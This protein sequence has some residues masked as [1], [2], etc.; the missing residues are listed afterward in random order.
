MVHLVL[1]QMRGRILRNEKRWRT[2][3]KQYVDIVGVWDFFVHIVTS[4]VQILFNKYLLHFYLS[5]LSF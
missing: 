1:N 3:K 2:N 5:L 4:K